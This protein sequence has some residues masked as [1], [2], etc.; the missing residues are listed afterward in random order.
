ML[1]NNLILDIK[2]NNKKL[3]VEIADTLPQKLMGLKNRRFLAENHGM[4]FIFK[5]PQR[6]SF[7]MQDT[8]I[9]LD[10]AY[11]DQDKKIKEI[12]SLNPLDTKLIYSKS[13]NVCYALEVNQGWFKKN[14]IGI[15]DQIEF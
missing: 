7:W 10:I 2:V 9:P 5:D 12:Y 3:I 15:D 13:E 8:F 1:S 11:V 4:L 14:N 6:V